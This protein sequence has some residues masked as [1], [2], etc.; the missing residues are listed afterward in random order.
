MNQHVAKVERIDPETGEITEVPLSNPEPTAEDPAVEIAAEEI[1]VLPKS[2]KRKFPV[3]PVLK[4]PEPSL[5]IPAADRIDPKWGIAKVANRGT[6]HVERFFVMSEKLMWPTVLVALLAFGLIFGAMSSVG[7]VMSSFAR[8]G[9]GNGGMTLLLMLLPFF[10]VGVVVAALTLNHLEQKIDGGFLAAG[11]LTVGAP[12]AFL[13]YGAASDPNSAL[14]W[15]LFGAK[16][17]I[18]IALVLWVGNHIRKIRKSSESRMI[19]WM[20][21]IYVGI[22]VIASVAL[23]SLGTALSGFG[24]GGMRTISAMLTYDRDTYFDLGGGLRSGPEYRWL[25]EHAPKGG[26]SVMKLNALIASVRSDFNKHSKDAANWEE[27]TKLDP[28]PMITRPEKAIRD[29]AKELPNGI[30]VIPESRD[31]V[32]IVAHVEGQWSI[33]VIAPFDCAIVLGP[34]DPASDCQNATTPK[35]PINSYVTRILD[36]LKPTPVAAEVKE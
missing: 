24:P 36:S 25:G 30:V 5:A 26:L 22:V 3:P 27:I 9:Y 31:P 32:S 19:L 20:A 11:G 23:A 21:G 4:T 2:E 29:N 18:A 17:A 28:Q 6:M 7:G 13:W 16:V 10:I 8:P 14:A 15:I 33:T 34:F 1:Y 12:L 35:R